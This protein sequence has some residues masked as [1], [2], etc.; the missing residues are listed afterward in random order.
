MRFIIFLILLAFPFAEIAII[1]KLTKNYGWWV[2]FY[3]ITVAVLGF[4]LIMA[5]KNL[6]AT[7]MVQ[8][9]TG[10]GNPLKTI[11]GTARNML[12]GVLLIIPGVITDLI[13]V[14]LLLMPN[15]ATHKTTTHNQQK[16]KYTSA[17]DDII[18]GEYTNVD[19]PVKTDNVISMHKPTDPKA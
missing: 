6:I 2:L 18:E 1:I 10:N 9:L 14:V 7:R 15:S 13:A 3:L 16:T 19:E 12:A 8:S 17:N 4:Q 5:E 11:M